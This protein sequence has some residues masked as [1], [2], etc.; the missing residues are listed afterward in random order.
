MYWD[1]PTAVGSNYYFD[2]IDRRNLRF[3]ESDFVQAMLD[4]WECE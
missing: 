1:A 4:N 2:Q 3:I